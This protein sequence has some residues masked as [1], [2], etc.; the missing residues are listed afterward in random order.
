MIREFGEEVGMGKARAESCTSDR[1]VA[2]LLPVL[3]YD[4]RRL[5]VSV[6]DETVAPETAEAKPE[7]QNARTAL[8]LSLSH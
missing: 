8:S 4:G 2:R 5:C 6:S 1:I 7:C 3:Q